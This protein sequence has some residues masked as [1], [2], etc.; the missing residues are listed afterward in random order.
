MRNM[1]R[2]LSG[3]AMA[4]CVSFAFAGN[5][6]AKLPADMDEFQAK[7]E[8]EAK[9]PEGAAK[10]WL[11]ATFLYQDEATRDLGRKI[12]IAIMK[13][14][15]QDFEKKSIHATMVNRIKEQPEIM[16]SYCAGSSPENGYK[17]DLDNCEIT[18]VRSQ[19]GYEETTW[20][21]WLKSSGADT[22]RQVTLRK[23]GEY[24]KVS[25]A[26]GL[27]MGIRPAVKK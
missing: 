18:V 27:Y 7:Y 24:W 25:N 10:L 1:I 26:P 9:T 15:P 16:R 20:N 22:E 3:I 2:L 8:K 12:L 11:E 13:D 4:A 17:A 21:L 5:A 23:E 14:L 6:M 19:Q